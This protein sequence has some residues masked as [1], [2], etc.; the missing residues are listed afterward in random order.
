MPGSISS[1]SSRTLKA[2]AKPYEVFATG[3]VSGETDIFRREIESTAEVFRLEGNAGLAVQC[4]DAFRRKQIIALRDT[5]VTLGVDEIAQKN[6]DVTGRGDDVGSREETERVIL[7]M[8]ERD[9]ISASLSQS[10]PDPSMLQ[11]TVQFDTGHID[12]ADNLHAL[13]E[14]IQKVVRL[15][16]QVKQ[17]DRKLGLSKEYIQYFNKQAK[18]SGGN[19]SGGILS[20]DSD[21]MDFDYGGAA[22]A[23]EDMDETVMPDFEDAI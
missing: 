10:G 15:N 13:K 1:V 11:T 5:Y 4:M 2:L 18:S 21:M 3:F 16:A 8:I 9:E 19:T 14:Q 6:F 23:D 17:M 22:W 7:G 12:E 20:V